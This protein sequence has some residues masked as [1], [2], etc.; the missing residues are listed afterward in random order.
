MWGFLSQRREIC[1]RK[2]FA[3]LRVFMVRI[4]HY[5]MSCF[6]VDALRDKVNG[7]GFIR[8]FSML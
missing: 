6:K 5:L 1:D 7:L 2:R 3:L 4:C 8:A